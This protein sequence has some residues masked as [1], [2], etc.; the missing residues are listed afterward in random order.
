MSFREKFPI[1]QKKTYLNSCSQGALSTDVQSAYQTYLNDWDEKG[2][3]WE[4]WVEKSEA[5][6]QA[7]AALINA[8]PNE[9]ADCTSV[10]AG[11][12]AVASALDFSGQRNEVVM[13]DFEFPTIG[14]IW[15]AQ[16]KRGAKVVHVPAAG[17]IIPMERFEA[18]ITE[19]TRIVS[20]THVCFRNGSRLDVPA[21]V[22]LAHRK[23]A[24]VLLDAYQALG[25]LPIDVK[26]LKVDFLAGGVLKYLLA[27]AGLA[28]MVVRKDLVPGL[29]PTTMGWF[30]QAN[31][32]AMDIYANTPSPTARRFES[33][34]PP[35][36]NIY[37]GL[38]GM[39]LIQ[40]ASIE[41]IESHI[42]EITGA[43][44]EGALQHG[45]NLVTPLDP[46]KHGALICLRSPSGKVDLLVKR[47]EADGVVTSSR[48]NNLRISPHYYNNQRDVDVLMDCLMKHKELLV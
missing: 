13:S 12:S 14:Q 40:S 32:F 45:F 46:A 19:R 47:L 1:F 39:K 20:I 5:A 2:S 16:E 17:N 28:F 42:Q 31:I 24:L 23:G 33:G 36:P 27:S 10:S 44:K 41:K 6:R 26:K 4:L 35:V 29:K 25:T 18:A 7:F 37:A 38:A 34:T 8:D 11:V 22:E 15:H 21:I 9:V 30:S 48:D 43:I 3:P